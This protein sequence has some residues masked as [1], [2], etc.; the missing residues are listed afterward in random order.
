[1]NYQNFEILKIPQEIINHPD[2]FEKEHIVKVYYHKWI[3][4]SLDEV[5]LYKV[6]NE[7]VFEYLNFALC[8]CC[9]IYGMRK[10]Q[11]LCTICKSKCYEGWDSRCVITGKNRVKYVDYD[12]CYFNSMHFFSR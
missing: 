3:K 9:G 11:R 2:R 12:T 5:G 8:E 4:K 7:L 1:M 10:Y 6:L